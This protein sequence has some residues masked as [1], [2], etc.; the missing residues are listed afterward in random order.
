MREDYKILN[1]KLKAEGTKIVPLF[2]RLPKGYYANVGELITTLNQEI[3]DSLSGIP[4]FTTLRAKTKGV[5]LLYRYNLIERNVQGFQ[6]GM[7]ALPEIICFDKQVKSLLDQATAD[8][9]EDS[10]LHTSG[11]LLLNTIPSIYIY[12]DIIKYQFVGDVKVPLL[13]VLPVQGLDGEKQYWSFNPP[14]YIPVAMSTLSSV[15]IHLADDKG[16][17]IPFFGDCKV[18]ARLHFRRVR[19][20]ILIQPIG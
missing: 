7:V 19:G 12:T 6:T 2:A 14:Y 4:E 15:N 3:Q 16:D 18:V 17:E 13:G 11:K 20:I 10:Q 8:L 5:N 1:E 9:S